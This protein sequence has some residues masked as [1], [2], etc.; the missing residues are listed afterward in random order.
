MDKLDGDGTF[1]DSRSDALDG[2]MT[3]ISHG[4]NSG[5]VSLEKARIAVK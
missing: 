1:S 2:A 5:N 4:K 3:N